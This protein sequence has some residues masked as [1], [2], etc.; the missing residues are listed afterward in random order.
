MVM[1]SFHCGLMKYFYWL[2]EC[3]SFEWRCC[4]H[5]FFDAMS[6]KGGDFTTEC[7]PVNDSHEMSVIDVNSVCV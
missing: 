2:F 4:L 3:G 1:E 7:H 6:C 5:S